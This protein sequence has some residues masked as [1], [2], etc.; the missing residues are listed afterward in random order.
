[1]RKLLPHQLREEPRRFR[2][3]ANFTERIIA[4]IC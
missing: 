1:M 4:K 2:R 3:G